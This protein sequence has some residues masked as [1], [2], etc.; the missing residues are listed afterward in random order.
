MIY[1]CISPLKSIVLIIA[2]STKISNCTAYILIIVIITIIIT[3]FIEL[4]SEALMIKIVQKI[5][6][7]K[8][9]ENAS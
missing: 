8:S 9:I 2:L 5:E 3:M 4:E 7:L 1:L 6:I